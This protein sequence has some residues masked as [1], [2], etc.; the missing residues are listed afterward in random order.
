MNKEMK[1]VYVNVDKIIPSTFNPDSRVNIK[2][3]ET[4]E[5]EIKAAGRILVPLALTRSGILADG[6]RRLV[7][8]KRLGYKEVPCIYYD[9]DD[10]KE[11]WSR[12]NTGT[13]SVDSRTWVEAYGKGLDLQ[14][15]PPRQRSQLIGL[16]RILTK[17]EFTLFVERKRSPGILENAYRIAHFCG[18]T[19][20]SFVHEIILWVMEYW[21]LHLLRSAINDGMKPDRVIEIILNKERMHKGWI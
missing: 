2:S 7:C 18:D 11:L 8:A 20:D 17:E 6:H 9:I 15:L 16:K 10:P 3:L 19:S 1:V 13:K 4:L 12:L 21:Q 14:Y 5:T